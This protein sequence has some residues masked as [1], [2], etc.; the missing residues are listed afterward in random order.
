MF[1]VTTIAQWE[2]PAVGIIRVERELARHAR[3]YL[4]KDVGFCLYD[5]LRG[6]ILQIDHGVADELVAGRIRIDFSNKV[7]PPLENPMRRQIRLALLRNATVYRLFQRLRGRAFTR[8]QIL[9]IRAGAQ[10]KFMRQ[11]VR[12]QIRLALLRNATVYHLF[13][14]LRGR[15]F[16]REQIL[17]FRAQAQ[18]KFMRLKDLPCRP[19]ALDPQTIIISAGLDWNYKDVRVLWFL[20]QIHQFCYCPVIYDLIPILAPHFVVPDYVDLLTDYF[21]E[22]VWVADHAMCISQATKREWLEHAYRI[23]AEPVPSSVF[24]LG[25]DLPIRAKKPMASLPPALWGKQFAIYVSTIDAR[26]NHRMLYEAWEECLRTK[27]LDPNHHR[28]VLVGRRGWGIGDLLRE[29]ETNPLTK[30]TIVLL[31]EM[32]DEQLTALYRASS[33]VLFPSLY[34]GF[35]LPLAEALGYGK[36]CVSS[37]TGALSEIGSNLV[38]RLDPKDTLL[39]SRTIGR[40]FSSPDEVKSWE[41]RIRKDYRAT[42][43]DDAARIFFSNII[44]AERDR[45]RPRPFVTN[46]CADTLAGSASAAYADR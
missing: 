20:K 26:K 19:A 13:Q 17:Q 14:R 28:L 40:L 15:V 22:L 7:A 39:W 42:T 36:L 34:E 44:S 43:W 41:E 25:C 23:G 29:I 18:V 33:F 45:R 3:R 9:Q 31:H 37:D 8:E 2:G 5:R 4:G 32:R 35:G 30:E 16:T 38:M 12:R 1:D 6:V 10:V 11:E 24:P 21:G 46:G 27:L